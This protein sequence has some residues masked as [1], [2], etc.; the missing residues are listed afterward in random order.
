VATKPPPFPLP[1]RPIIEITVPLTGPFP[2]ADKPLISF[3]L[4]AIPVTV[5]LGEKPRIPFPVPPITDKPINI[6]LAVPDDRRVQ[7]P[8][9]QFT[10]EPPTVVMEERPRRPEEF[11]FVHE[12]N[13]AALQHRAAAEQHNTA[14]ALGQNGKESGE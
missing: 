5:Q 4:P 7:R 2:P 10:M 3:G 11:R 9:H 13:A 6:A 12:M 1:Q 8:R 14:P